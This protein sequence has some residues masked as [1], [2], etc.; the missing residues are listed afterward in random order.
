MDRP[1][2]PKY[3]TVCQVFLQLFVVTRTFLAPIKKHGRWLAA[4]GSLG[5]NA[6]KA[7]GWKWCLSLATLFGIE[8]WVAH[9]IIGT[10]CNSPLISQWHCSR[11]LCSNR[12]SLQSV[13]NSASWCSIKWI[14]NHIIC[15][16]KQLTGDQVINY[17]LSINNFLKVFVDDSL[18]L[19]L[20]AKK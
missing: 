5:Y 7:L 11:M 3:G 4:F 15:L 2:K 12:L 16:K 19:I 18:V 10:F 17:R 20:I 8:F 13:L 1:F 9:S 14:N 6:E